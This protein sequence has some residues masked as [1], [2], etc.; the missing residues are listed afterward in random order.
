MYKR[1]P[2]NSPTH[3]Q[4]FTYLIQQG[5][6]TNAPRNYM[7]SPPLFFPLLPFQ[8][9]FTTNFKPTLFSQHPPA[10]P[11]TPPPHPS[12]CH[13]PLTDSEPSDHIYLDSKTT[14]Y[15]KSY[16]SSS[17][18]PQP[19]QIPFIGSIGQRHLNTMSNSFQPKLDGEMFPSPSGI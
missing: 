3:S 16:S 10:T 1:I 5:Y 15:S 13:K 2:T 18:V 8:G 19:T 9:R 12:C 11:S 4:P 14:T 6:L 7:W 17:H